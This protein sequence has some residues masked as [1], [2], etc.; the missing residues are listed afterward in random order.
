MNKEDYEIID[1]F[2]DDLDFQVIQDI[3]LGDDFPWF[4]TNGV[5]K[6]EDDY[7]KNQYQFIH[8]FYSEGMPRSSFF[9][10]LEPLIKKVNPISWLRIKAN[11]NPRTENIFEHGFHVDYSK[12][13]PNQRT[14]VFYLNSNNGYTL[15]EDGTKIESVKNRL[16]SFKTHLLHSGSTCNDSNRRVLLNLNY[17]V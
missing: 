8:L 1:N 11:L 17:I 5:N 14:A 2:L 7:A 4:Y 15:F 6:A 13:I 16:V 9:N 10:I 12:T 3:M